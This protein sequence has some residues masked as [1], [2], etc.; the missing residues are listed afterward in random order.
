MK[1]IVNGKTLARLGGV[2]AVVA[3]DQLAKQLA[4]SLLARGQ[5]VEVIPGFFNLTLVFNQGAAWG[6]LS[7]FR[8]G[9][10]AL[11]L[12][13]LAF[14]ALRH[15]AIFGTGRLGS[16]ASILLCGG[17]VGN[18]IDR[19]AVGRVTDFLDFWHGSYHFPCFNIADSAI[20]IGVALFFLV[21]FSGASVKKAV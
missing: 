1:N 18:L 11:A 16:A 17:I 10:I 3:L 15:D 4:R 6:M 9:F 12:A 2:A 14:I 20:C 5:P 21:S 8:Y 13:M 7:G 19:I